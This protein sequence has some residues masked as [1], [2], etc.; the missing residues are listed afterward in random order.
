MKY[1]VVLEYDRETKHYTAT[2]AGLP[3]LVIDAK[4]EKTA[5]KW[6]REGIEFYLEELAKERPKPALIVSKIV[7]V[8]V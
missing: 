3:G 1:K 8:E 2:V 7:T 5:I 6:A 4:S